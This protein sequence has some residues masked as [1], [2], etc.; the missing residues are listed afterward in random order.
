MGIMTN[1]KRLLCALDQVL[2]LVNRRF[3]AFF[4]RRAKNLLVFIEI[5]ILL[6]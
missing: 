3:P 6:V 5:I 1:G 4:M 2:L